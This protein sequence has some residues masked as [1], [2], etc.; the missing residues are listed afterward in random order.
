MKKISVS[1][2]VFNEK[3]NLDKTIA[4]AYSELEKSQLDFELWIFDNNSDDGTNLLMNSLLEKYKYLK[5]FRQ[6]KNLG[7]AGNF[8][9]ALKIPISDYKFIVDGDGQYGVDNVK[10]YIKVLDQGYDIL[11]GIRQPRMDPKIRIFMSFILKFLSRIILNSRLKDINSGFRCIT[12]E[13][14]QKIDINYKYN[15]VNPEI[16]SIAIINKLKIA[17]KIIKHYPRV[18]GRSELSG[19]KN[20]T[21]NSLRMIKYMLDL[22]NEI[23]KFQ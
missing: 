13:A 4:K 15:F 3:H 1:F 9:T 14:A 5:Y 23:K 10:D 20:L 12:S 8:Q 7:Y 6:S 16:F 11:I 21:Y 2:L 18:G 22:K 17:E 19:I